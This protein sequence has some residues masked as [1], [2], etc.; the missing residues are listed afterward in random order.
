MVGQMM[1]FLQMKSFSC[2]VA[3][4]ACGIMLAV[5]VI[6]RGDDDRIEDAI[7]A[8][9]VNQDGQV[10]DLASNFDTN[11]FEQANG[12]AI[13]GGGMVI[14]G[15]VMRLRRPS[16]TGSVDMP[17][18]SLALARLRRQ[19]QEHLERVD[20]T[21]GLSADQQTRLELALESDAR[22]IAAEIDATRAR[23][24]GA[25]ANF[26]QPEGQRKWQE[27]QQD[28]QRCRA[29]LQQAFGKD[30]L[31]TDLLGE[32]LDERQLASLDKELRS[33]RSFR[34]RAMVA[35]VLLKMD[36]TIGLDARQ[37]ALVEQLLVAA[38]PRLVLDTSP[39]RRNAHAEQMLVY[40]QLSK[41]DAQPIR[42]QLSPRQWQA[43]S[44]MMNQ[45]KAMKSWL[46][47]QGLVEPER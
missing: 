33:R 29:Q 8:G 21:C 31:F 42:E 43:V 34:W 46:D 17:E 38:E 24:A 40:H 16:P 45:G 23:Y 39:G 44:M 28:I 5:A 18:E 15:G 14:R 36:E 30:S 11:L 37:H 19:A 6:G 9:T 25:A 10:I 2:G 26:Q 7:A 27:F 12:L 3:V 32:M 47:Q 13:R 22:R 1:R 35:P 4:L 20:R 41:V